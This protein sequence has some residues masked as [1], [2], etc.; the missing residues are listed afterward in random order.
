MSTVWD[1][2]DGCT[3]QYGYDL[4]IYLLTLLSSLQGIKMYCAIDVPGHRYNVF[5]G[6]NATNF[7]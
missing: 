6:I 3:K 1:D 2:T 5:D 7:F 4:D